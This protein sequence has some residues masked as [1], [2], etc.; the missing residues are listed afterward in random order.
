M[1]DDLTSFHEAWQRIAREA[2]YFMTGCGMSCDVG[3]ALVCED[4]HPASL[5][6][7]RGS[8]KPKFFRCVATEW[9]VRELQEA[10]NG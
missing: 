6:I 9:C 2:M 1:Q 10:A 8:G 5:V 7:G 3:K 4:V